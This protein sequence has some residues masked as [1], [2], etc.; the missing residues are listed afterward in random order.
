MDDDYWCYDNIV[1]IPSIAA[2]VTI[3]VIGAIGNIC[4]CLVIVRTKSLHTHAN[5]CL[6]GLACSDMLLL[7]LACP[8][9]M[10]YFISCHATNNFV[11]MLYYYI[12]EACG[13]TSIYTICAFT[14]ERWLAVRHPLRMNVKLRNFCITL[15]SVGIL[16]LSVV[17]GLRTHDL[18]V[19]KGNTTE[20]NKCALYNSEVVK[21]TQL[22]I[23]VFSYI[24][25]VAMIATMCVQIAAYAHSTF[26]IA[27]TKCSRRTSNKMNKLLAAIV[28]S[29]LV[30]WSP[31]QIAHLILL[32]YFVEIEKSILDP[33]ITI[34]ACCFYLNCALNPILYN[35]FSNNFRRAFLHMI[36]GG[37]PTATAKTTCS[38]SVE[39]DKTSAVTV[40]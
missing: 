1:L 22:I 34:S 6:L 14:A 40:S 13:F 26:R 5:Y 35:M 15:A 7:F 36:S 2:L 23:F 33:I 27:R 39:S 16:A 21:Y 29:F 30:C 19:E 8:M 3:I 28:A 25:P 32:F 18:W 9:Q 31:Q 38:A 17:A 4:A 24:I 11:C 12:R 20:T 37:R 10:Y